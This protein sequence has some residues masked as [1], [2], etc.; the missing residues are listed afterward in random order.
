LT[1]HGALLQDPKRD[2]GYWGT[3]RMVLEAGLCLALQQDEMLAAG[4]PAGGDLTPAVAMGMVLVERLRAA[5]LV[6][7]ITES[8]ALL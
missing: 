4:L 8:P 7:R 5:G 2:P 3:S 1:G 6:L